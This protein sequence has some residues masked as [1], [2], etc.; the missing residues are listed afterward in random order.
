MGFNFDTLIGQTITQYVRKTN[1]DFATG[2]EILYL[3]FESGIA[4]EIYAHSEGDLAVYEMSSSER[5]R[6]FWE[7]YQ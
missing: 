4:I 7:P 5:K 2:Q 3:L 1:P 6:I